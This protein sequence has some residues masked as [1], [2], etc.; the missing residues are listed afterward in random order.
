[1][2]SPRVAILAGELSGDVLGAGLMS[3]L[4]G[5]C[6]GVRFE[7]VGGPAMA[8]Q[9]LESLVPMERLSLMGLTEIV[10]HLPGLLRLRADLARR[11]REDP[12]DCFIGVDLPDFNL[13]LA[14]RLRA[15]GIPTLHYVSP[16]IWAWRRGRVR[17]IRRSVDRM[18]TL[19]PFEEQFY[20]DSGVDAVC[21]GHPAA[22]RFPLQPDTVAARRRLGLDTDAT[23]VALL[24]GSRGSEIDR[25]L[26]PFLG[27]AALLAE[28]PDAPDFVIPVAAPRLRERIEAAVDRHQVRLRTRL[29]DGDTATAATAADVALTASGTATLEVMLAKRP[30]VVAYRL[31]PLSYQIIRRLI[32]VPWVSQPNLLAGEPLVPEYFQGDVT[33][34][35]LAEAAAYW[36]DE[37][38]ARLQLVR[39]FREL[40]ASLA[41][42]A[43]ARAAEAVLEVLR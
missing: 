41:R 15:A 11:W 35:V 24:P 1:M 2:A 8:A 29:L 16:T 27:A 23:V 28:R 20:A 6:P 3:E 39:R 38:P 40:H 32:H 42:G 33:P 31:S 43:D 13:G 22:D 14:R 9:G 21:V 17:G 30:M 34:Q 18:L 25:L 26:E 7:G 19:Y 10:R 36:L 5:R 37:A 4:R 12:P